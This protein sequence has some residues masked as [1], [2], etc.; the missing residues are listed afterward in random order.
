MPRG[1]VEALS[2]RSGQLALLSSE[3]RWYILLFRFCHDRLLKVTIAKRGRENV[4]Y[5]AR[6]L[7]SFRRLVEVEIRKVLDDDLDITRP[8]LIYDVVFKPPVNSFKRRCGL[9]HCLSNNEMTFNTSQGF[10][11]VHFSSSLILSSTPT[12][13]PALSLLLQTYST[14]ASPANRKRNERVNPPLSTL[15]ALLQLPERD[16]TKSLPGHLFRTGKAYLTFYKTG[17]KHIWTNYQAASAYRQSQPS[18]RDLTRASFQLLRRSRHDLLRIP[19]FLLI[20]AL[21]GEFTPLVVLT[22]PNLVPGTCWI[23]KQVEGKR[24]ELE[25]RRS[26]SF[27]NLT[28]EMPP[29]HATTDQLQRTQLLHLGS[30]LGVTSG[31]WFERLGWPPAAILK[32]RVRDRLEYLGED[33]GLIIKDGGVDAMDIEEVRM[34]L[35]ERGVDVLGRSDADLRKLLKG[36]I[37]AVPKEGKI[38]LCLKRPN[39]WNTANGNLK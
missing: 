5:Q 29:V 6:Q 16:P 7:P 25:R 11:A 26:I 24:R 8:C 23:P 22:V 1:L 14:T 30:T 17:L 21:C 3:D 34:A 19:P 27:R 15:P 35:A 28:T 20:F 31:T 2:L 33:D 13:R 10:R 9:N 38:R 18:Q 39:V 12:K 32:G 4:R 37:Q 36:W